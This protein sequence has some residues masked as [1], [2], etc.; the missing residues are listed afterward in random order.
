[1]SKNKNDGLLCFLLAVIVVL[2]LIIGV[3]AYYFLVI[4]KENKVIGNTNNIDKEILGYEESETIKKPT[5]VEFTEDEET[6]RLSKEQL[7]YF[8]EYFNLHVNNGFL[9]V[10]YNDIKEAQ[11]DEGLLYPFI[12]DANNILMD[13][14]EEKNVYGDIVEA[15]IYKVTKK[16]LNE[17]LVK[18][19]GLTIDEFKQGP[20]LGKDKM[21]RIVYSEKYD[22]Y[23]MTSAGALGKVEECLSG[24]KIGNV[25]KLEFKDSILTLNKEG[26]NFK[27]VSNIFKISKKTDKEETNKENTEK[28]HEKIVKDLYSNRLKEKNN[29]NEEK[30]KEFRIDSVKIIE[31]TDKINLINDLYPEAKNT[32]IF[33]IVTYS[34]K[35]SNINNTAW[36]AGNGKIEG[37]WINSKSACVYITEENG[38]Y[39]IK[40]DGTSW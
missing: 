15:D 1:M 12:S 13:D 22:A 30:F 28:D 33:A 25:Y 2:I 14:E 18:N 29:Y 31:G 3:G 32:D 4:E 5:E 36:I 26:E 37:E 19:T 24:E 6:G 10:E 35:P 38:V 20:E 34:I 7:D 9:I 16:Q 21:H 23:Y 11:L 27:V 39:T 40:G 17:F 8:T